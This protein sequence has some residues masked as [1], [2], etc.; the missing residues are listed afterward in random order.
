MIYKIIGF[1]SIKLVSDRLVFSGHD[2]QLPLPF[3][4]EE[5]TG[6]STHSVCA[7]FGTF[8]S[9]QLMQT[10]ASDAPVPP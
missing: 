4:E 8:P 2:S 3:T 9:G 6:Q 1:Y 5:P 10:E 7:S